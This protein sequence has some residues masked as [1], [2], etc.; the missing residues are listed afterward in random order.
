MNKS[1]LDLNSIQ[2]HNINGAENE[3]KKH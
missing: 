3:N 1:N 2:E